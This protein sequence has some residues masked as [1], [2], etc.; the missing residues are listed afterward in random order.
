MQTNVFMRACVCLRVTTVPPPLSNS[1][2]RSLG[3]AEML[4]F[5]RSSPQSP[6]RDVFSAQLQQ[7]ACVCFA[8]FATCEPLL[9]GL[10]CARHCVHA[11]YGNWNLATVYL[12]IH[13]DSE[14]GIL[15]ARSVVNLILA[16][17]PMHLHARANFT[18]I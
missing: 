5:Q 18:I 13:V 7:C 9:R 16:H 10:L 17:L 4:T 8:L 3:S 14:S 15:G 6:P 12:L 2:R 11:C 1:L